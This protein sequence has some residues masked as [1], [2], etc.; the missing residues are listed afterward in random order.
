[1]SLP[2]WAAWIEIIKLRVNTHEL[3]WSLPAWAAWIEIRQY[4]GYIAFP[5]SLPAWAAW[6]EIRSVTGDCAVLLVAARMGSV[7]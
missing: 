6:I 2:A 7:D 4:P 3:L 5:R 1:M